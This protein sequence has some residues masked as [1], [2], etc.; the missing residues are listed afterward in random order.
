MDAL[1]KWRRLHTHAKID[2]LIYGLQQIRRF[3]IV[4]LIKRH[5]IKPKRVLDIDEEEIDL[6]KQ[7]IEDLNE[8]LNQLFEKIRE[9]TIIAE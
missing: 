7:E 5:I 9:N 4:Q 2:D 8:K 1:N 3:D 6:K